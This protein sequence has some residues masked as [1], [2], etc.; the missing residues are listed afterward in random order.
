MLSQAQR[1]T[2]IELASQGVSKREIR[3]RL[4]YEHRR[5]CAGLL[6]LRSNDMGT[7]GG[8]HRH[9]KRQRGKT[10]I[11][12]SFVQVSIHDEIGKIGMSTMPEIH[13]QER[14]II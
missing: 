3:S 1:T 7:H 12:T 4:G 8:S 10:V 5:Q 9:E 2:I 6:R 14:Q 11:F 13:Q